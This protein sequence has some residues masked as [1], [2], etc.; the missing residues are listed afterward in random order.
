MAQELPAELG[1]HR[2]HALHGGTERQ[3]AGAGVDGWVRNLSDGRVEAVF[4]G[5]PEAVETVIE[6]CSEGP[7]LAR[8]D[9]VEVIEEPIEGLSNFKIR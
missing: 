6:Y 4:E 1:S 8:V 2:G 7:E 5:D 9:E 3:C